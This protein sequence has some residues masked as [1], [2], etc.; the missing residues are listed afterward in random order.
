M[1]VYAAQ[2]DRMDQGIGHIV[3]ALEMK[4]ESD[5]TLIL[6]LADNGGCAET[7]NEYW[8]GLFIPAFTRDGDS[9]ILGNNHPEVMPGPENTYQS[10]STPWANVS[11]TPFRLYKHW[12]HEGG[13]STPLIAYWPQKI[14]EGGRLNHQPGHLI[15]IMATCV[16]VAG[17]QYPDTYNTQPIVPMQGVSLAPAFEGMSFKRNQPIFWEHE[18]NRAIRVGKWKLVSRVKRNS[19]FTEED[20]DQWELYDMDTDRTEMQNLT[21]QYPERVQ[22]MAAL[23]ETWAARSNVKPWP[24]SNKD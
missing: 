22:E 23:W 5:N 12:V 11:N 17:T 6:F 19:R 18:G 14:I 21:D 10:Y 4:G 7:L 9:V 3:Q 24:W 1:A 2:V 8:K 15:D 16:D 13:I 20:E